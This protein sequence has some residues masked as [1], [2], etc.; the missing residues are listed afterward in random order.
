MVVTFLQLIAFSFTAATPPSLSSAASDFI[1]ILDFGLSLGSF[2]GS[3]I[4]VF[5]VVALLLLVFLTSEFVE[6]RKFSRQNTVVWKYLWN[7]FVAY[8][9]FAVQVAF[10]PI[11]ITLLRAFACTQQAVHCVFLCVLS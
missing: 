9:N 1:N 11:I 10:L 3:F 7:I 2:E 4:A 5:F 8:A 6:N